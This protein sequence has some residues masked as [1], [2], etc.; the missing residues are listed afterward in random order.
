MAGSHVNV[1]CETVLS[2]LGRNSEIAH[3]GFF[4]LEDAEVCS[5]K[6]KPHNN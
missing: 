1:N 4:K 6:D 5:R 2:I 3:D